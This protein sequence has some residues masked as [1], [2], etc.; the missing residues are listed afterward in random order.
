MKNLFYLLIVL[1][2]V[3]F[4]WKNVREQPVSDQATPTDN[5]LSFADGGDRPLTLP[6]AG[7]DIAPAT[8]PADDD[9]GQVAEHQV[10]D[11]GVGQTDS[12]ESE[13]P[14]EPLQQSADGCYEIGPILTRE[15]ADA[16]LGLIGSSVQEARV[17]IKTGAVPDGWWVLYPKA[18]TL[19]GARA[20]RRLLAKYGVFD[21]WI[22]DKGPLALA[23]SL[24]LYKTR[25]E[26]EQA[27]KPLL[28]RGVIVEVAPR[29]IR[30]E[31]FA[32][33]LNWSGL[34]LELDE[35]VQLL[36]SQDSALQ[37]PAPSQCH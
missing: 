26:A 13:K 14:L 25:G 2:V 20:N 5:S 7:P 6:A 33:K 31:V 19:E 17:V 32:L 23:I 24:G 9:A 10:A 35:K 37:M 28:D 36:N 15:A 11:G 12:A 30:G 4:V 18:R 34:P 16:Y 29:R 8:P 3:F 22:F 1:N 27:A 21:S